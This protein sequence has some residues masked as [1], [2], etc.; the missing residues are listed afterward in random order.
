LRHRRAIAEEYLINANVYK[1]FD[2]LVCGDEV[3]K[4]K[5]HPEI[6]LKG[7]KLNLQPQQCLMFEDS[8]NGIC[9][10]YDAGITILFKDIKEPNDHMS[11]AN[12]YYQDMYECLNALDQYIPEMD[13]PQ[14]QELFPQSLNQLT[15]G[16]H[17]FGAIGGGILL[18]SFPIGMDIRVQNVF[19]PTSKSLYLESVNSFGSYSIRYGQSSFDERIDNLTVIDADNDK[20]MLEMYTQSSL[21]CIMFA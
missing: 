3:E 21:D 17:G 15:V 13:M 7:T 4:G 1:F 20:Q 5:P 16:I 10:A 19:W 11:K 9:S 8:E 12:F 6:F 14:L 18:R 2:L